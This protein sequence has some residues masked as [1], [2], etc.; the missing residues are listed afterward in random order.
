MYGKPVVYGPEFEKYI[1]A[2]EL[3]ESG[4]GIS[5]TDALDLEKTLDKLLTQDEEYHQK[6]K[7]SKD[8]VFG[9]KGASNAIMA[10]IQENRLLTT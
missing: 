8:Y 9:K 7:A 1:E 6:C 2:V 4:G 3:Q 10:Y 5:V